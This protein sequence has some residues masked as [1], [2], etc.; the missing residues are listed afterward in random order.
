MK[1][2][3]FFISL[4]L[5]LAGCSKS[6]SVKPL[7]VLTGSYVSYREVDT[8][9]K[10]LIVADGIETIT[11]HSATGDTIYNYPG[12]VNANSYYNV[13]DNN[14]A[15]EGQQDITFSSNSIA[16]ETETS[17]VPTTI[18]YN[19]KTGTFNDGRSDMRERIVA[20]NANTVEMITN[21]YLVDNQPNTTG[22]V[23]A[24]YYRKQ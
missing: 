4:V 10:G 12:T 5:I 7:I 16:T 17:F 20:I 9:Y 1:K 8:L 11:I 24:V 23:V 15:A 18:T 3:L 14:P 13:P 6:S 19:L 2:F 22:V 21:Q